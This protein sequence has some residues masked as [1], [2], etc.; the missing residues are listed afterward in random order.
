MGCLGLIIAAFIGLA[1]L[2]TFVDPGE[3]REAESQTGKAGF[4]AIA[5]QKQSALALDRECR[6]GNHTPNDETCRARDKAFDDLRT[7]GVCWA[8]SDPDVPPFEYDWHDCQ[9]ANP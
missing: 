7:Q 5:A 1:I 2:G 8:Y 9:K 3:E 4:S 6:G